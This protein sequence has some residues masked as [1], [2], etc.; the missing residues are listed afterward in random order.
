MLYETLSQP[1]IILAI[2]FS[3]IASSILF[4]LGSLVMYFCNK[5]KIVKQIVYFLCVIASAIILYFVNLSVNYGRFR[6][7]ILLVF[8][9]GFAVSRFTLG[10]L[11]TKLLNKWYNGIKEFKKRLR[12]NN[13]ARGEK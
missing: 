5:N 8:A 11:W 9:V 4:N 6:I 3:G 12:R 13:E 2:L 10:K 1:L 7:Y